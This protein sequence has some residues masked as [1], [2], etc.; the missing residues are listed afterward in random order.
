MS[1][2]TY[3]LYHGAAIN[4]IIDFGKD[5]TNKKNQARLFYKTTA[6]ISLYKRGKNEIK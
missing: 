1:I 2:N 6:K 3:E 5:F 4:R